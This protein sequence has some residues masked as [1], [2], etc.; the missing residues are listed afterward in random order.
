M[1]ICNGELS[2]PSRGIKSF[3]KF[4]PG[5]LLSRNET[6]RNDLAGHPR[7]CVQVVSS[8]AARLECYQLAYCCC[9]AA[10]VINGEFCVAVA[11]CS[12][13]AGVAVLKYRNLDVICVYM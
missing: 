11:P 9:F 8:A 13:S 7:G 1:A 6:G 10:T 2:D 12:V 3:T 5:A 4:P